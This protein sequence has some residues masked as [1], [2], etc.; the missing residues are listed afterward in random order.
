MA[1][2]DITGAV[3]FKHLETFAAGDQAVVDEVLGIFQEQASMWV[4]L[5]DPKAEGEAWRDAAH[6]LKGSALGVGAFALADECEA[7]E[8]ATAAAEKALL[9]ESV[10]DEVQRALADIA[11][12]AH[13]QALRSLRS[14]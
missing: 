3:D 1:R 13:E 10:R 8:K 12:Y 9:V 11:A 5:L 4:R 14:S 7:A 6:T 2:R